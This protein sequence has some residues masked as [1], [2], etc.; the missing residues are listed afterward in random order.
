MTPDDKPQTPPDASQPAW[1]K[2]LAPFQSEDAAF[3]V[4]IAVVAVCAAVAVV[5]LAL[6]SI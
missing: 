3:R 6:R 2:L 5:A 4:L 1:M